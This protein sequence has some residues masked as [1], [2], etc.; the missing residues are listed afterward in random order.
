MGG[1]MLIIIYNVAG[2]CDPGEKRVNS[3]NDLDIDA[4]IIHGDT[5]DQN[6]EGK[7]GKDLK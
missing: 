1:V 3:K 4:Y 5:L 2:G 6:G 7:M